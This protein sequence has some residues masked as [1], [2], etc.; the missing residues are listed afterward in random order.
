MDIID[1]RNIKS[2]VINL[3]KNIEK[4]DNIKKRF[5]NL[6]IN[7]ERFK[8]IYAKELDNEYIK[9]VTHPYVQNTI[10]NGRYIDSDIGT[11][12]AVGCSLSHIK[13]WE[14]LLNSNEDMFLILEDDAI[15]NTS[16]SVNSINKY[17]NKI[18]KIDSNWD[19]IFL[20]YTKPLL[21]SNDIKVHSDIYKINQITFFTH[22]Y[23]INR[24]GAQ[25]LLKNAFPIIHQIDSYI[26]LMS[27]YRNLNSYRGNKYIIQKNDKGTDIQTD[28]SIRIY[29]NKFSDNS[30]KIFLFIF[31]IMLIYFIYHFLIKKKSK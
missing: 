8:A 20:G 17:L 19:Y 31:S 12:G 11:L 7:P 27:M 18:N 24:S 23:I 14:I 25:K 10:E 2:Y 15:P 5:F 13:L 16:Y 3:D 21:I 1:I 30:L 6:G 26:S 4:Y 9:K 29:I 22:A 28:Y